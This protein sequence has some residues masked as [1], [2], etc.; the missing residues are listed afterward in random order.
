[1][2]RL[3]KES[4]RDAKGID[5][6]MNWF[7]TDDY[8]R[9]RRSTQTQILSYTLKGMCSMT[10]E[11]TDERTKRTI[12][13]GKKGIAVSVFMYRKKNSL[14]D[15]ILNDPSTRSRETKGS[16]EFS[17]IGK[18]NNNKIPLIKKQSEKNKTTEILKAVQVEINI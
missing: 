10:D 13:S 14:W 5:K 2:E 17:K 11:R 9:L 8:C 15:S 3:L 7:N 1:M 12:V 16:N 4:I 6:T 18:K